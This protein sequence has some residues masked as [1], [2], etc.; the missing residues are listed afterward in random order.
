[1]SAMSDSLMDETKTNKTIPKKTSFGKKL[2]AAVSVLAS[3]I[4]T[5]YVVS[6]MRKSSAIV[7]LA[8]SLHRSLLLEP[9]SLSASNGIAEEE[10][11]I[12]SWKYIQ[13]MVIWISWK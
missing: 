10:D 13:T 5:G 11:G 8:D 6:S 9:G 2:V 7:S 1:M 4:L 12:I 3:G